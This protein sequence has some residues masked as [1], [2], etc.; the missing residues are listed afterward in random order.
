MRAVIEELLLNE[1]IDAALLGEFIPEEIAPDSDPSVTTILKGVGMIDARWYTEAGRFRGSTVHEI[2]QF[3]LEG[4][5][6]ARSV[7][8]RLRGYLNALRSFVKDTGYKAEACERPVRHELLRYTGRPDSWGTFH[9]GK[10]ILDF[11]TGKVVAATRFQLVGYN[12]CLQSPQS[13]WRLA[14]E[15]RR[16]GKYNLQVYSPKDYLKDWSHWTSMV[17]LYHLRRELKLLWTPQSES[18]RSNY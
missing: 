15:L 18:S 7:D 6:D 17:D 1:T 10:A 8:K 5:L 4:D 13:Y 11:K 3:E 12:G 16:D 14:V 2:C 9:Q